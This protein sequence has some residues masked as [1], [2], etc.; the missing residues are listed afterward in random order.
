M[1]DSFT[2][3][4]DTTE[5]TAEQAELRD[6]AGA[7]I[8]ELLPRILKREVTEPIPVD[9]A[10]MEDLGLTSGS[11]LE[12]ILE[13]EDHLDI[14]IDVEEIRPDDLRSVTGLAAYVARHVVDED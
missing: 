5:L 13:I 14:Q 8:V 7:A 10:L 11:T 4:A 2:H 3:E 9:A 6:R 12:L 1:T